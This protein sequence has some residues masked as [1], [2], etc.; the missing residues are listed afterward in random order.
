MKARFAILSALSFWLCAISTLVTNV[1]E[2]VVHAKL[3]ESGTSF[4]NAD[5]VIDITECQKMLMVIGGVFICLFVADAIFGF[6]EGHKNRNN[7][8]MECQN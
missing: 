4:S 7:Q 3:V 6:N 5:Y 2:K 8:S 1:M